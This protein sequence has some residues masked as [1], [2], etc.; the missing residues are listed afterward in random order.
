MALKALADGFVSVGRGMNESVEPVFLRN[1]E[2]ARLS[3]S[4]LHLA[5][6]KPETG[7]ALSIWDRH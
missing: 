3:M 1:N 6:P 5:S 2:V 7:F 4:S